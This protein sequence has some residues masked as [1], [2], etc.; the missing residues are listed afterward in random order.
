M[1]IVLRILRYNPGVDRAPHWN[2]YAV[3]V[4]PRDRLLDT[5]M[6][7]QAQQDPTLAFRKS[8]GHGVCGSDA[9]VVNGQ[10]R[11]ACKTLIEDVAATPDTIVT[12]EPLRHLHVLRDLI[13]DQEP[14]FGRYRSVRPYLIPRPGPIPD[15]ERL[16]SPQERERID[17]ATNC[18][19][20]GECYS[21]C[22]ILDD[23]PNYIGPAA[24]VQAARFSD[25]SRDTGVEPRRPVLDTPN[26]AWACANR[27]SCTR[28]CPRGIRVTR[29]INLTKRALRQQFK[30]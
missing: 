7:V 16:Q 29:L 14:F 19:L 23:N 28:V 5:L 24:L 17:D 30:P 18:I 25:D 4:D 1:N 9:M 3:E 8:C 20:C 13:V 15:R 2:D 12:V 6:A 21:A 27:F 11:L 10:E 22:P 26:G